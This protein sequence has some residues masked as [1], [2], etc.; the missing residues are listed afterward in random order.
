MKRG[1]Y[2]RLAWTGIR[3]NHQFY[4]PY[5]LTCTGMAMMFYIIAYL[6]DSPL[7]LSMKGGETMALI[8]SLGR[9]V[10]GIFALIFLFYTNSFLIRRRNK[11]FGLYNIL[12]MNKGNISR[13][14]LWETILTAIIS[15]FLGLWMGILF[16]KLAELILLR[17]TQSDVTYSL[18]I[19]LSGVWQTLAV[20]AVI[21]FLILLVSLARVQLSN[22]LSLLRSENTGE[23]PPKA[24]WFFALV[25]L[26]ILGAA[27]YLAVSIQEPITAI[28]WFFVAVIMVI[29]ATY[30][31][32]IAGS[33]ALC[34][35]LQKN[36]GYYYRPNHFVPVSSM[37]YRM[38]RNGAGLASICILCTMVLVM[39]SSTSCL[40]V[41]SEA[42]LDTQFPYDFSVSVNYN[43]AY[44]CN[45]ETL[46]P[47]RDL[48]EETA[49]DAKTNAIEYTQLETSGLLTK[50]GNLIV[51]SDSASNYSYSYDDLRSI[52]ILP[53]ADYNQL[54]GENVT[55]ETGEAL[56]YSTGSPYPYDTFSI[57]GDMTLKVQTTT[58]FRKDLNTEQMVTRYYVF[59]PNFEEY[60]EPTMS[61]MNSTGKYHLTYLYHVFSFDMDKTTAEQ[62][63][64][65]T[66]LGEKLN[67]YFKDDTGAIREEYRGF[68]Y[69]SCAESRDDFYGLYGSLFFLGILLSVVFI[70]A[71]VLIIYYKQ[72]SEGYEDQSRFE[73][74]QKVGMTN[75]EIRRS[76]NSQVLTVF[77]M[78]LL[79]AG[80]HLAFAFPL[81][82]K[83]LQFFNI[84]NLPLLIGVN[85]G[86]FCAF[87][88]CY[89][90]VYRVTS[91]V[92]Y[93]IVS[94][95]NEAANVR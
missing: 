36:K 77:F 42:A 38:K 46:S 68:S 31:L 2:L 33:V 4:T 22:P 32:F 85:V 65:K 12:G 82:W 54:T 63:Q 26:V 74:M 14:L 76:I 75:E 66:V 92:Y 13:I 64:W 58:T 1:F 37:V 80:L 89:G 95:A 20:F 78:P 24:N 5:I 9:F 35:L 6:V 10:I 21:F 55:L 18:S 62:L 57:E 70:F 3:K 19:A 73:I 94:G 79:M 47:V 86:C 23:K 29:I 93:G 15:L 83:I 53:L 59:I 52:Y 81:I 49:G 17:I 50:G 16:S 7:L 60:V 44:Q 8:L 51:H 61:W 56:I 25:G 88:L 90:L 11:E 84:N 48:I 34:R 39:L 71:A 40:F 91:N 30:L 69:S 67:D 87:G 72:I 27:Y 45:E 41:G 28:I 43:S